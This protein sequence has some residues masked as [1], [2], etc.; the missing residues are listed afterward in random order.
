MNPRRMVLGSILQMYRPMV[1]W[2]A[3]ALVVFVALT[4]IVIVQFAD[5][6]FS[7]WMFIAGSGVKYWFGV[8][9]VMSVAAHLRL[10][11]AA[12][13]T[14]RDFLAGSLLFGVLAAIAFAVF[15]TAGHGV[16][17]V[18]RG[19]ADGVP[20][21]YPDWS[22]AVALREIGH[23]LPSCLAF[24]VAGATASAGFYRFGAWIGLLLVIPALLPMAVSEGL[25]GIGDKGEVVSRFLP[26]GVAFAVSLAV[27]ALGAL[28]Y[29]RELRD[30]AIRATPLG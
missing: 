10:F 26:Y 14:R 24:L 25:L 30:V 3:A 27:T 7:L 20:P 23:I 2:F 28:V 8:V 18:L 9:G 15:V 16:E 19:G 13:I 12:G 29:R 1:L 4:E 5:P 11:V 6:P 17:Y 21:A 22:P